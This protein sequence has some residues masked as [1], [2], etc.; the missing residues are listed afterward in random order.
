MV[1]RSTNENATILFLPPLVLF[2][3]PFA[4]VEA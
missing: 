4:G 1:Q 3:A 2:L